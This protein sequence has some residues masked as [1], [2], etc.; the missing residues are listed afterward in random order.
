MYLGVETFCDSDF[1]DNFYHNFLRK[2]DTKRTDVMHGNTYAV[3]V[4]VPIEVFETCRF[5]AKCD[6]SGSERNGTN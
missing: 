3:L 1:G 4:N 2:T 5:A 6:L